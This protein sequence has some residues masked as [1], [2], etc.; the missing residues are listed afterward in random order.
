M[1]LKAWWYMSATTYTC[2]ILVFAC[3]DLLG[4]EGPELGAAALIQSFVLAA[5]ISLAQLAWAW[6]EITERICRAPRA[7]VAVDATLRCLICV[8]LVLGEG[9]AIGLVPREW[10][11]V[12]LIMPILLPVFVAVYTIAYLSLRHTQKEADFINSKINGK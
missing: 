5:S 12:W 9:M 1:K 6:L 3:V 4:M 10:A 11:S 2:L 8:V 7:Q